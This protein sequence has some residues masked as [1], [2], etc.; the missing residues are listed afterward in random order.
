MSG[1][2]DST[3]AE[4]RQIGAADALRILGR[5]DVEL[6]GLLPH[7]SNYT[8]LVYVSED[9]ITLPAVYKPT[10]GERPLWD[11]PSGTLAQREVAAF[12]IVSAM[13]WGFVPPTVLRDGPHGPGS[14]QFYVDVDPDEHY[15]TFGQDAGD[16]LMPMVLFDVFANNA[17]RKSGHV[18][19]DGQGNYWGIDHGLCFNYDYKLRTVMWDYAGEP[20]RA[21]DAEAMRRLLGYLQPGEPLLEAL[22][23]LLQADEIMALERRIARLLDRGMFPHPGPGRNYPWP[24]V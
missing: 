5:G 3:G 24:P 7:G 21:E 4:T 6:A 12:L 1:G 19:R 17:D 15:F 20:I 23:Q 11:F 18:L 8:F 14:I 2:D 9:G 10:R 22:G 13:D 16:A